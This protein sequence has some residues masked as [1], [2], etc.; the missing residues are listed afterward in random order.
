MTTY[1]SRPALDQWPDL[2]TVPSGLRTR[3][4]AAVARRLFITGVG[5]LPLTIHLEGRTLG[6]GGPDH[7]LGQIVGPD[8]GQGSLVGAPDRRP[9]GGDDHGFVVLSHCVTIHPPSTGS[10]TP[11]T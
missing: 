1:L 9:G 2:A 7:G 8:T 5:R 10:S 6:Q 3:I 11:L 4:P